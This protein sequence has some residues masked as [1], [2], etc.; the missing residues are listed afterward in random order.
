MLSIPVLKKVHVNLTVKK[1]HCAFSLV[2][3]INENV[4]NHSNHRN[5]FL[6]PILNLSAIKRFHLK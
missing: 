6:A 5:E 3:Y 1:H 2:M 4:K